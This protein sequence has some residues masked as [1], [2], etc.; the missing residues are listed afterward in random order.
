MTLTY[1]VEE[2]DDL[3][4]GRRL[5]R[6]DFRRREVRRGRVFRRSRRRRQQRVVANIRV[7]HVVADA[8]ARQQVALDADTPKR[9]A[10]REGQV[11]Q[12]VEG[13]VRSRAFPRGPA[14]TGRLVDVEE[15]E[16]T[17]HA[18][19]AHDLGDVVVVVPVHVLVFGERVA[20]RGIYARLHV[21]DAGAGDGVCHVDEE[22]CDW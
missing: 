16:G 20:G 13:E 4:V 1:L 14:L 2:G 6:L 3:V 21:E 22:R 17:G 10:L 19:R 12:G 18:G 7:G 8:R 5:R 9:W 11:G 15:A